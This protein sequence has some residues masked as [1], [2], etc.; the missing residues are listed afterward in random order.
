MLLLFTHS[1]SF[2]IVRSTIVGLERVDVARTTGRL[3]A[4]RV[5]RAKTPGKAP[6]YREYP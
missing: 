1:R 2:T 6:K 4:L 3:T 5:E